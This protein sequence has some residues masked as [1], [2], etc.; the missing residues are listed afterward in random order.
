MNSEK[1]KRTSYFFSRGEKGNKD[2]N[3][4]NLNPEVAK[5]WFSE[6]GREIHDALGVESQWDADEKKYKPNPQVAIENLEKILATHDFDAPQGE[7]KFYNCPWETVFDQLS[8]AK[9]EYDSQMHLGRAAMGGIDL[10]SSGI[11][12][13]P[14]EYGLGVIK[15]VLGLIFESI[16]RRV[17]NRERI[18]EILET[19][20]EDII[21]INVACRSLDPE[22]RDLELQR[23]FYSNVAVQL[24]DLVEVLLGKE[25]WYRKTL[26]FLTLRKQET[27]K[28]EDILSRWT[29]CITRFKAHIRNMKARM[30]GKIASHSAAAEKYGAESNRRLVALS[31][32]VG[33]FESKFENVQDF[34]IGAV[35][36]EFSSI[37]A[38]LDNWLQVQ[39]KGAQAQTIIFHQ[40]QE[41]IREKEIEIENLLEEKGLLQ[42]GLMINGTENN[43]SS[44]RNKMQRMQPHTKPEDASLP[45]ITQ[46]ELMGILAVSPHE[47]WNDLDYVFRQAS[48]F[49]A[50]N[51]G[52][53]NWLLKMD[54]FTSWIS[55]H[56]SSILLVEGSFPN[57]LIKPV[58]S[59]SI[60]G[61]TFVSSLINSPRCIVLFFFGGL[62]ADE[63]GR[64]CG[65]SGLI[66]SMIT[67][68]LLNDKLPKPMLNFLSKDFITACENQD[69][70]ALCELFERLVLQLPS[71]TQVFCVLDGLAW[72]EQEPWTSELLLFI[73]ML[74][75]LA[76]GMDDTQMRS[77][78]VLI[79]F[80]G[81]SLR[82]S[83]R[84]EK[85]PR[86]WKQ[87]SLAEGHIDHMKMST[88]VTSS[89]TIKYLPSDDG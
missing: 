50:K 53:A 68:L 28:I 77:L 73:S 36:V 8:Q 1:K 48:S 37:S 56:Q 71:Y 7:P 78:K 17:E 32:Q 21:I 87:V 20:P 22:P 3:G 63:E 9:G 57:N 34:I 25:P 72:Y 26:S 29:K 43:Y 11:D 58:T 24:P 69:L 23:A 81:R 30:M 49:D 6:R 39:D 74:E 54:E 62:Y 51:M 42:H 46:L 35:K 61:S 60:F 83:D 82:I 41:I 12:L 47:S 38:K 67:Q 4:T 64:N 70:N 2:K 79:T 33:G 76:K 80:A 59:L 75:Q 84:V 18:L 55:E 19:L 40:M 89:E 31:S 85:D 5:E 44:H 45:I 65:P 16:K 13:I 27:M 52:R 10:I 88:F 66:R 86:L 14:E 15:G